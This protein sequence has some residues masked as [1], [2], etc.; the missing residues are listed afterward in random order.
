[1]QLT[2][3]RDVHGI[4]SAAATKVGSPRNTTCHRDGTSSADAEVSIK[5]GQMV[6]RFA[7]RLE[8]GLG[9]TRADDHDPASNAAFGTH[10][11]ASESAQGSIDDPFAAV[12]YGT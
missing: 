10:D 7:A 11:L 3:P 2:R 5:M 6:D 9:E 4:F 12:R 8:N 1:M